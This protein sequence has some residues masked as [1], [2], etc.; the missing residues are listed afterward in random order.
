MDWQQLEQTINSM[1]D[2]YLGETDPKQKTVIK[3]EIKEAAPD[4]VYAAW[5]LKKWE[6]FKKF[7]KLL[8]NFPY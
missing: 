5:S 3:K 2:D 4:A 8:E 7:S 6:S 1:W